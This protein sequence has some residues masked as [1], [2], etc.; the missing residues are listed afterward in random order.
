MGPEGGGP[1]GQPASGEPLERG[2]LTAA[3]A[4]T[5]EVYAV[6]TAELVFDV[7]RI[8]LTELNAAPGRQVKAGEVR[9]AY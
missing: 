4:C 3:I 9:G 5:G 8:P 1:D 7:T 6:R 2:N